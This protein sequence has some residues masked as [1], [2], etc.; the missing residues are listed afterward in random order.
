[1][2]GPGQVQDLETNAHE[3]KEQH[4]HQHARLRISSLLCSI[5][6]AEPPKSASWESRP[7]E[8][9]HLDGPSQPQSSQ[10]PL[11]SWQPKRDGQRS[12]YD[13][14]GQQES[15]QYYPQ[16]SAATPSHTGTFTKSPIQSDPSN[17]HDSQH[18]PSSSSSTTIYRGNPPH[19][20]SFSHIYDARR[21]IDTP[22]RRDSGL[23]RRDADVRDT[24]YSPHSR[25]YSLPGRDPSQRNAPSE[26]TTPLAT[27]PSAS[28]SSGYFTPR[29]ISAGQRSASLHAE[30]YQDD[31]HSYDKGMQRPRMDR[32]KSDFA[33]HQQNYGPYL[34][35]SPP[36]A[37]APL[38]QTRQPSLPSPVTDHHGL[39]APQPLSQPQSGAPSYF[40]EHAPSSPDHTRPQ[41]PQAHGPRRSIQ[42]DLRHSSQGIILPP[43]GSLMRKPTRI[44]GLDAADAPARP[45]LAPSASFGAQ[46]LQD[47]PDG[48]EVEYSRR[49]STQHADQ[50]YRHARESAPRYSY[51]PYDRRPSSTADND[52]SQPSYRGNASD[53]QHYKQTPH[54]YRGTSS[55]TPAASYQHR[56]E[57]RPYS[58]GSDIQP[59]SWYQQYAHAV[60]HK[61]Q[62]QSPSHPRGSF[63]QNDPRSYASPAR[64]ESDYGMS[65]SANFQQGRTPGDWSTRSSFSAYPPAVGNASANP[66]DNS[67]ELSSTTSRQGLSSSHS[68]H[69][70]DIPAESPASSPPKA[71]KRSRGQDEDP[72]VAEDGV[73]AKRKRANAEQ[74]SVLN[75]AF[76]R[77]Y[78]PSTEE[79]LRLS[80]QTKM[81]PRTV[82][83][84]FQNKRQSVKARTEAMDAAVAAVAGRRRASQAQDR[85]GAEAEEETSRSHKRSSDEVE[86]NP[87]SQ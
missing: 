86:G 58:P 4:Q 59:P 77:S 50:G 37:P 1:M 35:A 56:P 28:S 83:I 54:E 3:H 65:R 8:A 78:F 70:F 80:K 18:Y 75:A 44:Y 12:E 60:P 62:P 27:P 67:H 68:V 55:G 61:P 39:S 87:H 23:G 6:A 84:W 14:N 53:R 63:S 46:P 25:S 49:P 26:N 72:F 38:F 22:E 51:H 71:G 66:S 20:Q 85:S 17:G 5:E 45:P 41:Y 48:S 33:L 7:T 11:R 31:Y 21:L 69:P 57:T 73:K 34:D 30:Y 9:I 79:R 36:L 2:N 10:A 76:E 13:Y 47:I 42:G 81:C 19:T 16:T 40:N 32:S 64:R 29:P 43:P 15:R 52:R 74:L 24:G 82:Q